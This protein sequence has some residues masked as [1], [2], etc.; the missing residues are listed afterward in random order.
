MVH[1]KFSHMTNHELTRLVSSSECTQ[2]EV[3][4][5]ARLHEVLHEVREIAASTLRLPPLNEQ[6]SLADYE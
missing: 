2:L 3:E 6:L 5:A 1:T 4:L